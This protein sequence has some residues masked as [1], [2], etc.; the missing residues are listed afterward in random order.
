MA[1]ITKSDLLKHI[2]LEDIET[3]DRIDETETPDLLIGEAI[4]DAEA[5]INSS[6]GRLFDLQAEFAKTGTDRSRILVN[7]GCHLATWNLCNSYITV[8]ASNDDKKYVLYKDALEF[9]DQVKNGQLDAGLEKIAPE[10]PGTIAFGFSE[11][12]EIIY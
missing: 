3:L 8:Q 10:S 5:F 12:T 7:I 9:L 1:Y 11:K 4:A 2:S 6:I